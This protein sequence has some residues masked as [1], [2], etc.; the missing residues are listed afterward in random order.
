MVP[1]VPGNDFDCGTDLKRRRALAE[2]LR[3]RREHLDPQRS[4]PCGLALSSS[5]SCELRSR[6]TR[7]GY[8]M[9]PI[10]Y[11]AAP[12]RLP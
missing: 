7:L 8:F 10:D 1:V 11:L 2:F 5:E 4:S 9:R 3:S 6:S 12:T